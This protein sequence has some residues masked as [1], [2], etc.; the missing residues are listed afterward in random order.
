M[1]KSNEMQEKTGKNEREIMKEWN[2][3]VQQ[4]SNEIDKKKIEMV[5]KIPG[6]EVG[7]KKWKRKGKKWENKTRKSKISG[8]I[9]IR[10]VKRRN[11]KGK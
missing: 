2:L 10:R 4:R 5:L 3:K 8:K 6:K 1:K 9:I 11:R 7:R